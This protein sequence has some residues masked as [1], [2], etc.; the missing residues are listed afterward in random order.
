M[1]SKKEVL[2]QSKS[3]F[4]QWEDTWRKHAKR[5]GELYKE[6][7]TSHKDLLYN[8][9]GKQLLCLGFSPSFE[10]K[11][12]EIKKYKSDATD[13]A[14]VEKCLGYLLDN[15]IKP[16]YIFVCD[17]GIDYD[18]WCKPWIQYTEDII[19][20]SSITA[21]PKF[22]ENWLGPKYFFCNKDNIESE[23]IFIEISGC[24]EIIPASSNVGNSVVVF[25]TQVLGY[26]KYLLLGL[27]YCWFDDEN[28]YAFNDNEKRYWM[29]HANVIDI[30][31]RIVNTSQN[32]IFSSRWL[33]DFINKKC[34]YDGISVYNCS[35]QGIMNVPQRSLKTMLEKAQIRKITDQEKNMIV[36]KK[37]SSTVIYASPVANEQLD[38]VLKENNVVNIIVNHISDEVVQCLN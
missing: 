20:I 15:E 28:Y 24:K 27:D 10:L 3:A 17:A 26:D 5:N 25:S 29:K 8:G 6:A 35:G 7:G 12:E 34:V 1:L 38:K 4:A 18:R 23:K 9:I 21:N 22:A 19:L 31:G 37:A 16:K 30:K 14:A 33:E 2:E 11:I 13:I 36:N 32:L